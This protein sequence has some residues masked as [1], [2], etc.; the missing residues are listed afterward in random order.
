MRRVGLSVTAVLVLLTGGASASY[1]GSRHK[2]AA[3][4][5]PAYERLLSSDRQAVV[6]EGLESGTVTR[7]KPGGGSE[8]YKAQVLGI[9]GCAR[10]YARSYRLG[11]PLQSDGGGSAG[12]GGSGVRNEVLSGVVVA[13]EEFVRGCGSNENEC[14]GTFIVVVRN[15]STGRVVHKVPTGTLLQP[16]PGIVGVGQTTAIVVK[17]DGA[18]A[19]ITEASLAEGGYQVHALDKTGNRVLAS[20]RDIKPYALGLRGSE[21]YWVEGG[22][23]MSAVLN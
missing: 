13:Y 8:Y 12:F 1:A 15:L 6:Y 18:V 16:T 4:C 14:S 7:E 9:R 22:K 19:W 20:N 17:N 10:G 3:K 11:G 21:L 23:R 2:L 5:P